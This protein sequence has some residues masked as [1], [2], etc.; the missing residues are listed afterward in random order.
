MT[1]AS[2]DLDRVRR[3]WDRLGRSDP[4]GAVLSAPGKRGNRWDH[5]QFF[6][7]GRRQVEALLQ[8]LDDEGISFRRGRA[9][10]FGCGL[11]RLTQALAEHFDSVVGVD[12]APSMIEGAER[13]NRY[14]GRVTYLLNEAPDL[15]GLEA[16]SFDFAVSYV[17]LQH[18][19]PSLALGYVAEIVRLLAPE[20][21]AVLQAP[22]RAA[23]TPAGLLTALL[24]SSLRARL[25]GMEMHAISPA[26]FEAEVMAAGASVIRAWRDDATGKRWLSHTYVV[27]K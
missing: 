21:V 14:P 9:L 17:T 24:P 16:A 5:D 1:P 15:R 25:R 4:Y 11:G 12:I 26:D 10:D 18:M 23:R 27:R 2:S 20:G 22:S 6:A 3:A 19:K 7:T 13:Y 8:R